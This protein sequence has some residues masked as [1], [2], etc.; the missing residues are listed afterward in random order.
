[1]N[2]NKQLVEKGLLMR[3]VS[4]VD[5]Y[6][7]YAPNLEIELGKRQISPLREENNGSFALFASNNEILFKDFVLGGGDCIRFVQLKFGYNFNEALSR[8]VMDFGLT[9]KYA[10]TD[11]SYK[12]IAAPV[13]KVDREE[14]MKQAGRSLIQIR[15]RKWLI[16]DAKFWTPFGID[17]PTLQ[18]YNVVPISHLFI[19]S[20]IIVC[21]DHVYAFIEQKDGIETYKIYQPDNPDHKWINNH[22]ESVWQGWEQLPEKGDKVIITKSLKDIMTITSLTGIPS[23]SLQAESVHPKEHIIEELKQRFDQVWIWYDNDFDGEENWGRNFGAKLAE[24][25]NLIQTE[26]PDEYKIKDPSDFCKKKGKEET[27]K[28]IEKLTEVPF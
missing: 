21:G 9:D 24:E 13:G 25:H 19:N 7:Y 22:D 28:L 15:R 18:K 1:M 5:I 6:K 11:L 12:K 27:K 14:V 8:I 17:L 16:R 10:Y 26:I 3:D 2:L 4:D 23:V 20:Q